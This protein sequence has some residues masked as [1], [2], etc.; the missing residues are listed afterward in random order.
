MLKI[1]TQDK[2][3]CPR[4]PA[5][6]RSWITCTPRLIPEGRLQDLLEELSSTL[7]SLHP[8]HC[9]HHHLL[10]AGLSSISSVAQE[11]QRDVTGLRHCAEVS[12][13]PGRS[14]QNC[15]PMKT[16][17]S[18]FAVK[19][20]HKSQPAFISLSPHAAAQEKPPEWGILSQQTSSN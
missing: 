12:S 5:L 2:L 1:A 19:E 7:Q 20:L 18:L 8:N 17:L 4:S 15:Y 3:S 13:C 9:Q 6:P 11:I 14:K 16:D 10:H